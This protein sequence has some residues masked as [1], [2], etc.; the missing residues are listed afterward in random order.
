M[1][2]TAFLLLFLLLNF[3]SPGES[4]ARPGFYTK[5]DG[6]LSYVDGDP[7]SFEGKVKQWEIWL[8]PK[9]KIKGD[10]FE[11]WGEI[12]DRTAA[13]ATAQ[14]Q[15]SQSFER[16][17]EKWCSC[18]YGSSTFFNPL[19]PIAV[20][21]SEKP[22]SS[23]DRDPATGKARVRER[24]PETSHLLDQFGLNSVLDTSA[25]L[26]RA[27]TLY[28]RIARQVEGSGKNPLKDVGKVTRD[29]LNQL[30]YAQQRVR[31]LEA[32]GFLATGQDLDQV[33]A[34]LRGMEPG[35][36]TEL[37][38][39]AGAA[40]LGPWT[41]ETVDNDG[42]KV[43]ESVVLNKDG[44]LNVTRHVDFSMKVCEDPAGDAVLDDGCDKPGYRWK[45][46]PQTAERV[47]TVRMRSI[48]QIE[49]NCFNDGC[50]L[51]VSG[52]PDNPIIPFADYASA[53][54][55]LEQLLAVSRHFGA[56]PV[57]K[58]GTK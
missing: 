10:N 49:L 20:L 19:G 14:L 37:A 12:T 31:Q 25:K 38:G 33:F 45:I 15:S 2:S 27:Y 40:S 52:S 7:N 4:I 54:S 23:I 35:V 1:G 18:P 16:G 34:S 17:W 41:R 30:K 43:R 22:H 55:G 13:G 28:N 51:Y 24:T 5:V 46:T 8:F 26:A 47:D 56:T 6:H 39:L 42:A 36:G 53:K 48:S 44:N 58:D 50:T 32:W 57:V 21:E 9:G 3:Q 11:Y 29:Y